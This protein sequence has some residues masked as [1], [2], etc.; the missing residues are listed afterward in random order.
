METLN[1]TT[2]FWFVAMGLTVGT[3]FGLFIK[4]EGK[5]LTANMLWGIAGAV[6]VGSIALWLGLGDGLLFSFV[7]TLA[8]LFIANVFHQHHKEDL[9]GHIDLGI[10]IKRKT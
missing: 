7:G 10:T 8:V 6:T 5:S 2:L 9:F 1:G 3:V 4:E